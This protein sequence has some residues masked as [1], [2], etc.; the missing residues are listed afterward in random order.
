[1]EIRNKTKR[2]LKIP[3]PGGKQLRLGPGKLGQVA[4]KA[5]SHPPLQSLIEAGEIEVV[6]GGLSQGT[7]GSGGKA[8]GG[9][10]AQGGGPSG[11]VRHTGDR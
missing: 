9:G 11:G 4:P 10:G 2:P 3:L 6:S 5:A 7:G 1:M 8:G